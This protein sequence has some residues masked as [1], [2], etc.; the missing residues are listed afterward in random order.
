MLDEKGYKATLYLI[1]SALDGN[2]S[3]YMTASDALGMQAKGYEIGSHSRTHID[4]AT[5]DD[6][7][8]LDE[9]AG[10]RTEL[11]NLGFGMV[12]SFAYPFG[13]YTSKIEQS[14]KDAGYESARTTD[15]G[16]N[17]KATADPYLLQ[18]HGMQLSTTVAQAKAWI[19]EAL[20][21]KTWLVLVLH[22]VDTSG[23]AYSTPPQ[24]LQE[25]I[26]YV[27]SKSMKVV[28]ISEGIDLLKQ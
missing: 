1:S 23:D 16:V 24:D 13:T 12:K 2:Y 21:N 5:A 9:V 26:N 20:Q 27:A 22:R 25:V 8:L 4:L 10:S 3:N 19:D 18:R 14:V 7:K 6:A 11:A 15:G 17:A 28:T